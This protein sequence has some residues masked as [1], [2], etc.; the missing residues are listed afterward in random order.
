[1]PAIL[2]GSATAREIKSE[3]TA[4]LGELREAGIQPGLAAVLVGENPASAIYVRSKVQACADLGLYSRKIELPG[5]L[6][7]MDLLTQIE[8]L[9]KDDAIDGILVQLPLPPQINSRMILHAVDPQKDVDGFHPINVGKLCANLPGLRPCTPAGVMELLRRSRID[10]EGRNAVVIGR[11]DIVGKPLALLLLHQNATVTV[12]HSKTA[13]LAGV[14]RRADLL[15]A[16]IGRA[17]LVTPDFVKPGAVLVDVG[18][19][20]ITDRV[21]AESFFGGTSRM[22]TF[23][24]K[25]SLLMGDIHPKAFEMSS[26]Y[27]PVPGGVG[28]LTIAMLMVNTV[29]AALVRRGES[30]ALR[31]VRPG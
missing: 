6:S 2:D 23:D 17:G 11:S 25:G 19:N 31:A 30:I 4:H 9:N 15:F 22:E 24:K 27:T 10:I 3:I 26:A 5:T 16:A 28:P 1:M 13:D 7:T 29:Q 20:V 8:L 14:C 12:C 18:Q 21:K